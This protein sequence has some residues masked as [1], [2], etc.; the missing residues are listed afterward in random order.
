[1]EPT[2]VEQRNKVK[3]PRLRL[4]VRRLQISPSIILGAQLEESPVLLH[5]LGKGSCP[6][7]YVSQDFKSIRGVLITTDFR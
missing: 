3:Y 6:F 7:M 1:M 2:Q 4:A 5:L